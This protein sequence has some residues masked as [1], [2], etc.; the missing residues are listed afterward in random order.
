MDVCA[1]ELKFHMIFCY[2]CHIHGVSSATPRGTPEPKAEFY[3]VTKN[4]D[5]KKFGHASLLA[6]SKIVT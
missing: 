3:T 6:H 1:K 4:L 5:I 2:E